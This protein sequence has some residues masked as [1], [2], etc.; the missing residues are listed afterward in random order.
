VP[1]QTLRRDFRFQQLDQSIAVYDSFHEMLPDR[2]NVLNSGLASYDYDV[3]LSGIKSVAKM[4]RPYVLTTK[5]CRNPI[6]TF[7]CILHPREANI[8]ECVPGA[9]IVLCRASDVQYG[10]LARWQMRARAY[11][12]AL[13]RYAVRMRDRLLFRLLKLLGR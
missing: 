13:R 4:R 7:G 12:Y 6:Q 3:D 9:D 1:L 10:L 2:L 11:D 5:P 8:A